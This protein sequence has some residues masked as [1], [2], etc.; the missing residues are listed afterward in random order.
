MT[1]AFFMYV[2]GAALSIFG[3]LQNLDGSRRFGN[4]ALEAIRTDAP[5][6]MVKQLHRQQRFHL[7]LAGVFI[8]NAC[9]AIYGEFATMREMFR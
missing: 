5:L 7:I 2:V 6:D 4:L 9:A 1:L 3:A 8:L